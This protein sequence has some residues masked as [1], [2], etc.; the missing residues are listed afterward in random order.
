MRHGPSYAYPQE[1]TIPMHPD[2]EHQLD[3]LLAHQ[4]RAGRGR[5]LGL[6]L[7]GAV[8]SVPALAGFLLLLP[9]P[10][11][12]PSVPAAPPAPVAP[13]PAPATPAA[14]PGP[15]ASRPMAA[16][17]LAPQQHPY[18]PLQVGTTWAYHY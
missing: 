6:W 5:R 8:L 7:L 17:A 18:F 4:R 15:D 12:P 11:P 16:P 10:A 13:V 2:Y 1:K 9:P 14:R 3:A